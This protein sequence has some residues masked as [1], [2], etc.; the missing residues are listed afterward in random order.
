[1]YSV[2]PDGFLAQK[3][4]GKFIVWKAIISGAIGAIVAGM[5][6]FFLFLPSDLDKRLS[7]LEGQFDTFM[8]LQKDFSALT[9]QVSMLETEV[10]TVS[11]PK[12]EWVFFHPVSYIGKV[13]IKITPQKANAGLVHTYTLCWGSWVYKRSHPFDSTESISLV[14]IKGPDTRPVALRVKVSPPAYVIV[15]QGEPPGRNIIDI[16]DGWL[17]R[18]C[19]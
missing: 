19:D 5:V 13:W 2:Q 17:E 10:K 4:G 1:M 18:K 14:H 12:D 8:A 7:R 16:N 11:E 3:N 6:L 9:Q 15:G